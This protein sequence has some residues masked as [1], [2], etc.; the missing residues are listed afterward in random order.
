MS[1]STCHARHCI[2]SRTNC[3]S[4]PPLS[5]S[6]SQ[7]ADDQS[8]RLQPPSPSTPTHPLVRPRRVPP[9]RHQS[10]HRC[11]RVLTAG[12]PPFRCL[13]PPAQPVQRR[14][15]RVRTSIWATMKSRPNV[16]V[17][18]TV[19]YELGCQGFGLVA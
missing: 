14:R 9:L 11:T 1:S 8:P 10:P 7:I 6:L 3:G 2:H 12:A 18:H 17:G 19:L 13:A 15:R 5:L 4:Q 16:A